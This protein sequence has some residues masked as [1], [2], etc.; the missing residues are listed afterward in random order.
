MEPMERGR[1]HA[2]AVA[3]CWWIWYDNGQIRRDIS[4]IVSS[5]FSALF[6]ASNLSFINSPDDLGGFSCQSH[7]HHRPPL[8][9]QPEWEKHISSVTHRHRSSME[10]RKTKVWDSIGCCCASEMK[11]LARPLEQTGWICLHCLCHIWYY[12]SESVN[13]YC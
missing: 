2:V 10:K 5:A 1:I 13:R 4:H 11:F 12:Y 6:S 7:G 3:H 9:R 8:A